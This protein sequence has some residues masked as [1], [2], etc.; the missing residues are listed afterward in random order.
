MDRGSL[1]AAGSNSYFTGEI[2]ILPVPVAVT[3]DIDGS[4]VVDVEDLNIIINMILGKTELNE[5]C[6]IN[7]D[8]EVDVDDMNTIINIIL[9]K[10]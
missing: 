8:G 4:G 1:C 6:D 10:A 2:E 7:H 5:A 9:G 3:G